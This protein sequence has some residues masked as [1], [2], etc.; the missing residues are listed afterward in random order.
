MSGFMGM[1]TDADKNIGV[2]ARPV[3]ALLE[4]CAKLTPAWTICATRVESSLD[5]G[6]AIRL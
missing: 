1:Q 4:S 5:D 3:P 6:V 2:L